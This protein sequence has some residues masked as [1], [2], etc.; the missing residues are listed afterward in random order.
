MCLREFGLHSL[1]RKI[2]SA[3]ISPEQTMGQ[4]PDTRSDIYAFGT[5]LY[6]CLSARPPFGGRT[7]EEL[8]RNIQTLYPPPL[9]EQPAWA[10][11]VIARAMQRG[12]AHRYRLAVEIVTDLQFERSPAPLVLDPVAPGH[13]ADKDWTLG[14][15]MPAMA[16]V[17]TDALVVPAATSKRKTGLLTR[18]L[19]RAD[20]PLSDAAPRLTLLQQIQHSLGRLQ[21]KSPAQSMND[22]E[23]DIMPDGVDVPIHGFLG[24]FNRYMALQQYVTLPADDPRK[25]GWRGLL[26]RV[27]IRWPM[28]PKREAHSAVFRLPAGLARVLD[29]LWRIS[30]TVVPLTFVGVCAHALMLVHTRHFVYVEDVHGHPMLA[31]AGSN[32]KSA[33]HAGDTLDARDLPQIT[34]DGSSEITLRA[35]GA[36]MRVAPGSELK[37]SRLDYSPTR[38]RRVELLSGQAW[39]D[40]APP[41][42][43]AEGG[44]N[45]DALVGQSTRLDI[46]GGDA[47]ARILPGDAATLLQIA[48]THGKAQIRAAQG[49]AR[50]YANH[51]TR[52]VRAGQQFAY[53]KSGASGRVTN[54][55]SADSKTLRARFDA[56]RFQNAQAQGIGAQWSRLCDWYQNAQERLVMP[57]WTPP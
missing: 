37:I 42:G 1:N 2:I 39:L 28:P 9:L 7:R 5:V 46:Q 30:R 21:G 13:D 8:C 45:A 25:R 14:R 10:R 12:P 29:G 24:R 51:Q 40:I 38:A 47:T 26:L 52:R 19:G 43:S 33:I 49:Q 23:L 41:A 6:A 18:L 16:L 35:T 11:D 36:R 48:V 15:D 17:E 27:G 53:E 20:D 50:I 3:Y 55:T 44:E 57:A 4:T 56:A 31:V 22:A 54:L 32:I 34:T